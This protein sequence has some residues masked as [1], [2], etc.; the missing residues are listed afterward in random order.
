V[1]VPTSSIGP[2]TF[3]ALRT[4]Q[5][6][7]GGAPELEA[8]RV[9]VFMRPGVDGCSVRRDGKQ[10]RPFTLVSGVDVD[11]RA[12]AEAKQTD[13]RDLVGTVQDLVWNDTDYN[14]THGMQYVVLDVHDITITRVSAA[15]GGLSTSK[16]FWVGAVWDLIPVAAA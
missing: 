6:D 1:A 12:A 8:E 15:A 2:E 4:P 13:Y 5:T 10:G 3:V 9:S 14:A 7:R 11:N 16:N